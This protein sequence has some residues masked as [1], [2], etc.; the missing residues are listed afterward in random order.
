MSVSAFRP[1]WLG[2]IP[3]LEKILRGCEPPIEISLTAL[4]I[5]R[6]D[7]PIVEQL[8]GSL[9]SKCNHEPSEWELGMAKAYLAMDVQQILALWVEEGRKATLKESPLASMLEQGKQRKTVD[10]RGSLL[11][12]KRNSPE[13]AEE[14]EEVEEPEPKHARIAGGEKDFRCPYYLLNKRDPQHQDCKGKQFPNPRKLKYVLVFTT[15]ALR[16]HD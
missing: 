14:D 3:E 10:V 4:S 15:I 5:S 1:P 6:K 13:T 7:C 16:I 12:L 9:I 11:P 8:L 2:D